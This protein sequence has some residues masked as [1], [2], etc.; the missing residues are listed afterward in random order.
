M[1]HGSKR[2]PDLRRCLGCAALWL[3]RRH[4][5][6]RI[7]AAAQAP[8][9]SRFPSGCQTFR[10]QIRHAIEIS[11]API[12]TI[13]G[14]MKFEIRNCGTANDTPVTR[15]AGQ[16]CSMPR[17]PANTQI[18]QNG[19]ISE[20]N[21]NCRPT[22]AP[23]RNGSR[24]VTLARPGDRRAE[25]A[26]G[27][28]RGV[29]DQRKAGG[30]ERREAEPDQDRAGDGD[31]RAEARCAFEEGAEGKRD[32]Q[33]LQAAIRGDAADRGLQRLE[34][35]LLDRQP[36]QKDDVENDPADREEAGD[37]AE[38]GRARARGRPAS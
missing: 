21:G 8:A 24:P 13:H 35:A 15:M 18:S 23:S 10:K 17:H 9:R 25:R 36:V 1:I 26:V 5:C 6:G 22:I 38:H 28:R 27:N 32:Q 2:E 34:R 31:R 16:I 3:R 7:V 20:K 4:G 14:L 30:R 11:D 19:T 12:S 33:K 29:G 37:R